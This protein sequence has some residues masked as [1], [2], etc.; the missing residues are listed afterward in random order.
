MK[1]KAQYAD[2]DTRIISIQSTELWCVQRRG[3]GKGTREFDPWINESKPMP[4]ALARAA[5]G[6]K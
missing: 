6:I 2:N 1:R 4:Y 5:A 3:P